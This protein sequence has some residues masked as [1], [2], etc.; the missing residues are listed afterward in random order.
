M[1]LEKGI[2]NFEKQDFETA[3][4]FFNEALKKDSKNTKALYYRCVTNR[5]LNRLEESLKDIDYA[6]FLLP[7][8]ADLIS[9]KAVTLLHLKRKEESLTLLNKAVLLDPDNPYRYSSRA[10]VLDSLGKVEEA[11]KDYQ[12]TIELDPEDA[13]AHN[14]LGML[15]E[16]QGRM[17]EANFHFKKADKIVG[18]DGP[19]NEFKDISKEIITEPVFAKK[20]ESEKIPTQNNR[21]TFSVF[22]TTL[23][24]VLFD[25]EERKNFISFIKKGLKV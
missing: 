10:F 14:N 18:Y 16:K 5:R 22:L 4:R 21:L 9:E 6:L 19:K 15:Q 24:K 8:N 11:I 3:L 2:K 25:S 12:R 13:V 17:N 20:I 23:K 1:S 7:T